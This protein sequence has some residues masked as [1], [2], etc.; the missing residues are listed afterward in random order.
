VGRDG[1]I[2]EMES[3]EKGMGRNGMLR[4][5]PCNESSNLESRKRRG[6]AGEIKWE[7]IP[8]NYSQRYTYHFQ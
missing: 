2:I 1:I 7:G 5:L 8:N 3:G 4:Y 6:G